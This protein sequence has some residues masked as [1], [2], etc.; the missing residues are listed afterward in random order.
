MVTL[1]FLPE[2]RLALADSLYGVWESQT[3][4]GEAPPPPPYWSF[5]WVGGQALARYLLDHRDQVAGLRVLDVGTGSGM[6]A[7]AA[8]LAGARSVTAI[9]IDPRALEA[10]RANAEANGVS[11]VLQRGDVLDETLDTDV[12]LA[13]DLFYERPLAERV[14]PFL[15]RHRVAL[16]GDAG[17]NY[18]PREAFVEL[19]RY[20]VPTSLEVEG[21]PVRTGVVY[22]L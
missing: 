16:A 19:A 3:R 14:L 20:D 17:R 18:F 10:T 7:I 13:G 1:A 8:A 6:V 12:V 4:A 22:R 5:P 11:L 2:L 15:R 21:S 9:D